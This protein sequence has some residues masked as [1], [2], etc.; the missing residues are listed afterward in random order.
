ME[1][2][3][4]SEEDG[5]PESGYPL[6]IQCGGGVE[7]RGYTMSSFTGDDGLI[8]GSETRYGG[9]GEFT[10]IVIWF[11]VGFS[12]RVIEIQ[13]IDDHQSWTVQV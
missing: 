10:G 8:R 1:I 4:V 13:C 9:C 3:L 6:W 11:S 7:N 5:Q 2:A 12:L